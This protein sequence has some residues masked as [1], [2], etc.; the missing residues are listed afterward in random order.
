M[1]RGIVLMNLGSPDSTSV[2]DVRKYLN[3]FLMDKRVIDIPWLSRLLLV[4]GIIVPFRAPKSAN[5]YKSIWTAEGSPLIVLTRQLEAALQASMDYP[6]TIAMRYGTPSPKQAYEELLRR[7]PGVEEVLVIPLYP[8][9]AMSSYETAAEYAK[10]Q[11]DEGQYPFRLRILP[12]Y[13]NEPAYLDALADSFRPYLTGDHDHLLFS[14]HGVPERHILKKDPD[15]THNLQLAD[16]CCAT[17]SDQATCYRYQC[18]YTT[19]EVAKRLG[20]KPG[21]FSMSFQSRLGREEW[22]KP[23]TAKRLEEMPGEGIKKLLVACPAFVSDCLETLEEIAVEGKESFLHAGGESFTMIPCL[24][25]QPP[26]VETLR[27][28]SLQP[29]IVT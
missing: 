11:Y 4:R 18:I 8:H 12:A 7:E 25:V 26:W 22:L 24:N 21:S 16:A 17:E 27:A 29:E 10:E 14:Y 28:Y 6:V 15:G 13:Y 3:E 2:K 23:Y 20:L 19:Q 1:K 9:Y 5:A